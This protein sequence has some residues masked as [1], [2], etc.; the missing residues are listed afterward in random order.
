MPSSLGI[1]AVGKWIGMTTMV[2]LMGI[3]VSA[4]VFPRPTATDTVVLES[5]RGTVFLQKADDGWFRTAHPLALSPSML[6]TI[7]RGVYVQALPTNS[8]MNDRVFS[9]EDTEFLG[10]VMS[11]AL[12][13]ATKSQ[14]VGFRV[15]H[16]TAAGQETTGGILY[17]QGRLLHLTFTHFRARHDDSEPGGTSHRLHPN[18]TGLD[19][20]Q[21]KFSPEAARRSSR[22][23][24]PDV[25][26]APPLASLV[27][28]YET[29]T[30]GL[31]PSPV[32][33]ESH[34]LRSDKGSVF[35]Q[36]L[37]PIL[38]A[39]G[40]TVSDET[41]A[42]PDAANHDGHMTEKEKELGALQEEMRRLQRRL[43]DLDT[44]L[45]RSK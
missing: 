40:T 44:E 15:V 5:A 2:S 22:N 11:V 9:D 37:G 34:P 29:L 1:M 43:D 42:G 24:Q 38:P 35:Q 18:P 33:V 26:A 4:C 23:E 3:L 8:S 41:H 32:P 28:D 21:I 17:L 30:G 20:H 25:T 13:K 45:H 36:L 19:K 27:L 6:I 14:V 12:S 39:D 31:S 10:P 16:D 7:L